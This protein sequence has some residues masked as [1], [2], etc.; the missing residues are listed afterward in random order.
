MSLFFAYPTVKKKDVLWT[1]SEKR[2]RRKLLANDACSVGSD[3]ESD[4]CNCIVFFFSRRVFIFFV[5][6]RA[7]QR[8]CRVTI[9]RRASL[10]WPT[11][12]LKWFA[13]KLVRRRILTT[14]TR[15]DR[16]WTKNLIPTR[17]IC[18][19]CELWLV[20]SIRFRLPFFSGRTR[21]VWS[22]GCCRR[23]HSLWSHS[24]ARRVCEKIPDQRNFFFALSFFKPAQLYNNRMYRR[25]KDVLCSWKRSLLQGL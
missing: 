2:K 14:H 13:I 21:L 3:I 19:A 15:G 24:L 4:K 12:A 6:S 11:F 10:L 16:C 5:F 20:R 17:R 22:L 7:L 25:W 18:F 8:R 9:S 23:H 1:T